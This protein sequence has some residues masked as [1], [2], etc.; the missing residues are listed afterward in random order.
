[1]GLSCHCQENGRGGL[2]FPL[3]NDS[4][5]EGGGSPS[6]P[7]N[8]L[9]DQLQAG[10]LSHPTR[11]NLQQ[12]GRKPSPPPRELTLLKTLAKSAEKFSCAREQRTSV[13]GPGGSPGGRAGFASL[14]PLGSVGAGCGSL[15]AGFVRRSEAFCS[16]HL[17]PPHNL[18]GVGEEG[19]DRLAAR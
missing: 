6:R 15:Y 16:F 7:L 1:M 14:L 9:P 11:G 19:V 5:G 18:S 3:G 2:W 10:E 17:H 8:I 13:Q 4:P 12:T